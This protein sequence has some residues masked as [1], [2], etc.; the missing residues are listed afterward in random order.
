MQ[1][2]YDTLTVAAM[3]ERAGVGRTSFYAHFSGM[4]ALFAASVQ[5]LGDGLLRAAQ[6]QTGSWAFLLPF[7]QHVDSHR[8][9]YSGFVG[10]LSASVLERQKIGRAHV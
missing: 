9:V 10:R 5:R 8:K 4:E 7:L 1:E 2:P 6:V 3:L